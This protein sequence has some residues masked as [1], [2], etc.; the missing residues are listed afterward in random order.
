[1]HERGI[2]ALWAA[3][4]WPLL[5]LSAIIGLL[6]LGG[7]TT[8]FSPGA[9]PSAAELNKYFFTPAPGKSQF[10]FNQ[11]RI[12]CT[13][14]IKPWTSENFKSC[15][16]ARG[17]LAF[18]WS[19]IKSQAEIQNDRQECSRLVVHKLTDE[20]EHEFE[21]CLEARGDLI[22]AGNQFAS[23]ED[24]QKYLA[25]PAVPPARMCSNFARG[26]QR[27]FSQCMNNSQSYSERFCLNATNK[28]EA[29][30]IQCMSGRGFAVSGLPEEYFSPPNLP[31][32][33]PGA[34][35]SASN[36]RPGTN[37][38][39]VVV[40]RLGDF[41]YE[42]RKDIF[43]IA[44]PTA[45]PLVSSVM[46]SFGIKPTTFSDPTVAV[47]DDGS[48]RAV[49][50][51][52]ISWTGPSG[53]QYETDLQFLVTYSSSTRVDTVNTQVSEPNKP[54]PPAFD[55]AEKGKELAT[56]WISHK[57]RKRSEIIAKLT[58]IL[59]GARSMIEFMNLGLEYIANSE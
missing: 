19:S 38:T 30:Y 2:G 49:I 33:T 4:P 20:G 10:V 54:L 40:S 22:L 13:Y 52:S 11:D 58:E 42:Y 16:L 27:L 6:M 12:Q 51:E 14:A 43:Y 3:A 15:M 36:Q 37:S 44:H 39:T 45:A 28:Q 48:G 5:A 47:Q 57:I 53:T 46:R 59:A 35:P 8:G 32:G 24:T 18:E 23:R 34:L 7:C 50:V 17:N 26:D 29:Q 1:M 9:R 25:P 55:A 21:R 56:E 31:I 41:I